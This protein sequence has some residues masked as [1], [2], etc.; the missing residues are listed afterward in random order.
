M[1]KTKPNYLNGS[2]FGNFSSNPVDRFNYLFS[3][4]VDVTYDYMLSNSEQQFKAV[5]LSGWVANDN[6]GAGPN[7]YS[8]K[9]FN[10]VVD[11]QTI[12]H[13]MVK[14][15]PLN[16]NYD[17]LPN[18]I[19]YKEE[20]R[21]FIYGMHEWAVSDEPINTQ[22]TAPA[23]AQELECYYADGT[24]MG[25]PE[26]TLFY[27]AAN[28]GAM[29][30]SRWASVPQNNVSIKNGFDSAQA[31]AF[32]GPLP[33]QSTGTPS[34]GTVKNQIFELSS[35][36][37]LANALKGNILANIRHYE[38]RG[39]PFIVNFGTKEGRPGIETFPQLGSMTLAEVS[40]YAQGTGIFGDTDFRRRN[41]VGNYLQTP[42][43]V[44]LYQMIPSTT[45]QLI[46]KFQSYNTEIANLP[47]T[48]ENQHVFGTVLLFN[49]RP[50]IGSYLIG[51]SNNARE[52]GQALAREWAYAPL[53]Y[54][55]AGQ[56]R[57]QSR[58]GADGVNKAAKISPE[59]IIRL[60]NE[61]RAAIE[62]I[63]NQLILYGGTPYSLAG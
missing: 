53:Q 50:K 6:T 3:N 27:K 35:Y 49:K 40:R 56:K 31:P 28:L 32:V 2:L 15:K 58:Y 17:I 23:Y 25:L 43:A 52:A 55:E 48:E 13:R 29:Q 1:A 41:T 62:L 46:S 60:L 7:P 19:D 63:K 59:E 24:A 12:K 18:P 20:D 37:L 22:L 21:E 36:Y 39:N 38:S 61:G 10:R 30:Q 11:G 5:C 42:F 57:G 4:V 54:A 26:K 33:P 8:A 16:R 44:G 34:A 9:I 45:G 51:R 47:F 14:V